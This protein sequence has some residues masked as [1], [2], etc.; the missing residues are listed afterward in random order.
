M[1]EAN[2]LSR[3]PGVGPAHPGAS[4]WVGPDELARRLRDAYAPIAPHLA[5]A[6]RVFREE[7]GSRSD[8]VQR[9]VDHSARFRGKQ[10]RP[11]LVL[12]TAQA[13]GG[14]RPAHPVVAAVVEMIHTATLV[15]DD[16]LDEADVR[17]HAATINA[18]WGN[19]AAVLLGDY[20]FTHAF[21]LAASLES[22]YACRVIG[23]AT[24]LVCEGELQQIHHRGDLDLDEP[25][26]YEIVRGKTA[27]LTAVSC[28]LGA[29][30]AGSGP[31]ACEAFDRFGRDL[32]VAFQIA[33]DLLDL[34]GEEAATG[35]T[36]GTDLEKQKL[37]LPVI[38]LL[39]S[40]SPGE[41]DR[42]RSLICSPSPE[43]RRALRPLLE[44]SGALDYAWRRA[45]GFID[46][47][48]AELGIL[49]PSPAR[50]TLAGLAQ[51]VVRRCY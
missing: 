35:K 2:T 30:Y 18:E 27:E 15:H 31:E 16:I 39:R 4:S 49:P 24:N 11:A 13:C 45:R 28:R 46:S 32:G 50:D 37:T 19:E 43:T 36:L 9:L 44:S 23:H 40:A 8:Y 29:H 38:H 6:E 34:Y 48:R 7:L 51:L 10:L 14:I 17:R 21:H 33:D 47:A 20:L 22:A 3:D 26:Y 42:L 25:A 1:V 5:E 12:L 41:A